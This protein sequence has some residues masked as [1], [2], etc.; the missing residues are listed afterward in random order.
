MKPYGLL[1]LDIIIFPSFFLFELLFFIITTINY[2]I[3]LKLGNFLVSSF[4]SIMYLGG[5]TTPHNK[6]IWNQ[7][8]LLYLFIIFIRNNWLQCRT[9]VF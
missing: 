4:L 9:V 3:L 6:T 2:E 8:D 5:A 1:N 7:P